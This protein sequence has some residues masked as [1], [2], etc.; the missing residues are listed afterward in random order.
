MRLGLYLVS[1]FIL[2]AIIGIVVYTI[3]PNNYGVEEFGLSVTIPLAIWFVLPMFVL[4]VASALHMMFYGTKN[5]FKFKKWEKDAITL[6]DTLYWSILQEPKEHSFSLPLLKDTVSLLNCSTVQVNGDVYDISKKLNEVL[7]LVHKIESGEYVDLKLA[8]LDKALSE[9]NPL[10]V[11][12]IM[13]R[14]QKDPAFA[15]EILQNKESY[16]LKVFEEALRTFSS[17]AT[18]PEAK[19]Y[20]KL[21]NKES[22][23]ILLARI[24]RKENLELTKDILDEFIVNLEDSLICGDYL[25]VATLMMSEL[26]PDDNLTL[27]R[28]YES[29]YS[30]SQIAYLYLLFDY[31]MLEKAEEYLDEHDENDFKRFRALLDLKKL[32][33]KYRIQDMM[34]IRHICEA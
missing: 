28:E 29:K 4:M 19:K 6:E 30:D 25:K 7:G 18:F 1:S 13:N 31:E 5:F 10:M 8:K 14:L 3:N 20:V 26:S 32:H 33:K 24:G 21:Y 2:I 17:K 27:W 15:E 16:S 11:K 9:D 34:D 22:F 12:N 23:F